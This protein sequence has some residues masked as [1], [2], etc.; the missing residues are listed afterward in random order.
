MVSSGD[1]ADAATQNAA[2]QQIEELTQELAKGKGANDSRIA[3]ILD[4][5]AKMVPGTVAAVVS[6]F[7]TPLLGGL[8]EPVTQFVL[9]QLKRSQS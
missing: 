1:S 8:A 4:G 3:G 2:V 9:N 6:S 7:G 5:L